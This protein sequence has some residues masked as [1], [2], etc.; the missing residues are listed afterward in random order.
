ML[1]ATSLVDRD[2]FEWFLRNANA[3]R[4]LRLIDTSLDQTFMERLPNIC[5]RLTYLQANDSFGLVTDLHFILR[6]EQLERF[7][8]DRQLN[9]LEFAANAHRQL[10]TLRAFHFRV[11]VKHVYINRETDVEDSYSLGVGGYEDHGNEFHW[12]FEQSDLK[13][14]ELATIYHQKIV[15]ALRTFARIN[16]ARLE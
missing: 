7:E 10:K 9:S 6:F 1:I 8:T 2:D 15:D 12:R 4:S 13:W 5:S 14:A 3:L 16:R 11:G